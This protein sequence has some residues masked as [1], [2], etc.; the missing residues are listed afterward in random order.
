MKFL[1]V[2]L[3][4]SKC[5]MKLSFV[6]ILT[7]LIKKGHVCYKYTYNYVLTYKLLQQNKSL[8]NRKTLFSFPKGKS[9]GVQYLVGPIPEM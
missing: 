1:S 2:L 3:G 8:Q 9:I 5:F 4:L 6:L 7:G